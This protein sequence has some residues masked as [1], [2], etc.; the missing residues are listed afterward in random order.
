MDH[1]GQA[2]AAH[3][4]RIRHGHPPAFAEKLPWA[5][6]TFRDIYLPLFQTAALLVSF[7]QYGQQ[8][9]QCE[10]SGLF[11]HHVKGFAGKTG[12]FWVTAQ[13]FHL[14]HFVEYELLIAFFHYH[15]SHF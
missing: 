11:E 12:K 15:A 4:R 2:L 1:L 9:V 3:F 13:L 7:C 6:I 8:V 5:V 10:P 14:Q